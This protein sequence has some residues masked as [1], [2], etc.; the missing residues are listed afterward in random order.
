MYKCIIETPDGS[1]FI[2][3]GNSITQAY[4]QA[5]SQINAA[6]KPKKGPGMW[7]NKQITDGELDNDI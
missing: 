1:V 4:S 7:E 2:G 6:N 3:R 5:L